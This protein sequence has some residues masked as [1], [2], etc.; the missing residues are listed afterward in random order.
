MH[1][2]EKPVYTVELSQNEI[3][4]R[5]YEPRI[6]AEIT[7]RG[8]RKTALNAGFKILANFIFG[9]ND[10][11]Q[12][13]PMLSPVSQKSALASLQKPNHWEIEF[14]MPGQYKELAQ[15]PKPNN[16]RIHLRKISARSFVVI[17]FSGLW[18]NR[19][20]TKHQK[21]LQK[22]IEAH[23]LRGEGDFITAF[24]DPPW[25]L[26]FLRRNEIMKMLIEEKWPPE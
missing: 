11:H 1:Y 25:R 4:I 21:I 7:I 18:N 3:E 19:N 14:N 26:A 16:S 17:K 9:N 22:F 12:E 13:I 20:F 23:H 24:Y 8:E 15:I 10:L 2:V 5:R 6:V